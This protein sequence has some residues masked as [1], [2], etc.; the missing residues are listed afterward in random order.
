MLFTPHLLAKPPATSSSVSST[1]SAVTNASMEAFVNHKSHPM[2]LLWL[3]LL[4]LLLLFVG[5]FD[6]CTRF[7]HESWLI[8]AMIIA[9]QTC[10]K[11]LSLLPSLRWLFKKRGVSL[12]GRAPFTCLNE[13]PRQ[14]ERDSHFLGN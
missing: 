13:R 7:T 3:L 14:R 4:L 12:V 2:L 1:S 10:Y 8:I 5:S 6:G 11:S 9:N